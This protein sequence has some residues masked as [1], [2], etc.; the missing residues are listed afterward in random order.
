MD[1]EQR[2]TIHNAVLDSGVNFF[3]TAR[4]YGNSEELIGRYL[5]HRRADFYIATKGDTWTREGLFH[6]LHE[7]LLRLKTD[8]VDVMQL[9]NPT[10]EE[11]ERGGLVEALM[12][13]RDEGKV[14]WIGASTTLPH[15]PVF[16]EWGVFDVFQ[17]P[18]S[19]L[20]RSHEDWIARSAEAGV[21]I[22][23]RGGVARGDPG[24]GTG[25]VDTW[26]AFEQAGLDELRNVGESRTAFMLRY[27]LSNPHAHTV[28]VGT[29]SPEHL[30]ENVRA[31]L[32]GGLPTDVYT[33]A[34]RRL[35]STN[36]SSPSEM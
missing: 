17:V 28:I 35:E 21:G 34:R 24:T 11:C 31:T 23:V 3:D 14:R 29:T 13:M 30:L 9:H 18:Y 12:E 36:V 10:V 5:S 16:L 2:K 8:Y 20:Q 6:G 4:S 7:S 26:R 1:D 22:V 25:S 27:T 32:R 33:E 19:A 15:L